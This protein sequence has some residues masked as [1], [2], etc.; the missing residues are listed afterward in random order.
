VTVLPGDLSLR[1]DTDRSVFNGHCSDTI[2]VTSSGVTSSSL[3]KVAS[4][5]QP[6]MAEQDCGE[7]EENEC[8]PRRAGDSSV[9]Q[10]QIKINQAEIPFKCGR[11]L[12]CVLINTHIFKNNIFNDYFGIKNII[13]KCD[14]SFAVQCI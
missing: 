5:S 9:L 10:H 14:V 4:A 2:G 6:Q 12:P 13:F 11:H 3:T 7:G 8:V 1:P